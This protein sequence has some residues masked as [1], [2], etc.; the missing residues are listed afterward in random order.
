MFHLDEVRQ[1]LREHVHALTVTIGERSVDTPQ[2]LV[3]TQRYITSAFEGAGL[4]VEAEPFRYD[5]LLV[6]NVIARIDPGGVPS[7]RYLLGAHSDSVTGTVGADDNASAVAV[8]LETARQLA[9][10]VRQRKLA[11]SVTCV[12]FALEEPPV[13][14]T[15][16]QASKVHAEG[17]RRRGEK[18]DGMLCLEMVGYT[19]KE[20]GCQHYPFPL[21]FM[22]YPKQG[23]FIG[24]VGDYASRGLTRSLMQAFRKNPALPAIP[25]TVPWKGWLMPAVRLSDHAAFWDE[26]YRA[27]MITDSAFYRNPHYHLPSDT[28]ETLDYTFMAEL[29]RSLVQFFLEHGTT[30]ANETGA[31]SGP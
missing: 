3:K 7:G 2:N 9:D 11:V 4:S 13:F 20:R 16:H 21:G 30:I 25:L 18:I 23:D 10:L 22:G 1:A 31:S 27:V 8:L 5:D 15:R 17:M 12:A 19:C 26:G 24:I 29:T 28:A 14:S 6:A